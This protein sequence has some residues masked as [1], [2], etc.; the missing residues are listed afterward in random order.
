MSEPTLKPETIK[1]Q[2]LVDSYRSGQ[3]VIPEF[4]REYVWKKNRAPLLID[5]LYRGFPVSSLLVWQSEEL[6]R[7]RRTEPRVS[8]SRKVDWLI[9]GQQRVITLSRAF[10]GDENIDV[11]FNPDSIEFQ[12]ANAATEKDR[13]WFHVSEL[14]DDSQYRQ[15]RKTLPDG[16]QSERREAAFEK[17][18]NILS[19]EIPLLRMINHRFEDAV[20]AFKRINRMGV[21]LKREDLESAEV[22]AKHSGF[23]ADEVAPYLKTLRDK[24]FSRLTV[25]HLFRACEYVAKS[26][27]RVRTPLH[28][29]SKNEVLYAWKIAKDSTNKALGLLKSELGLSNMNVFWSGA[30][31]VP[32]IALCASRAPRDL[33]AKAV[34][35]WAALAALH[36]R[37][38][39]ST[40]SN[41]DQDL[42]ACR[43][44][45]PIGA[46]LKNLRR[47]GSKLAAKPGDF[48]G[49][50]NDKSALLAAYVACRHRGIRDFFTDQNILLQDN[51]DR[52]HI[53][54]RAQFAELLRPTA[55]VI[56]NI[57][58]VAGD[59][60]RSI[61][62]SGPEVYLKKI[63]PK[64]LESQC[65]PQDP[66]LWSIENADEFWRHRRRL[67]AEAF[68]DYLRMALPGRKYVIG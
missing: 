44:D 47:P 26:D 28:E 43:A 12:L 32:M 19:Y 36:H 46:L 59:V 22:A 6:I 18:R 53:L 15:I 25:M 50:L 9:D 42:R 38:S 40:E 48:A 10:Y 23:I 52:H 30:M 41:L 58:F 65:V 1:V 20:E 3:I 5:S 16:K 24:G 45:D 21:R 55:D 66:T 31:F 64:T 8:S 62:A 27:G 4:Q 54:P 57:A 2:F 29:L 14:L 63:H 37:Y 56:A 51:I 67:L 13:N 33:D 39:K 11:V 60:N 35:A 7:P 49:R 61:S 68:N 17:L 34:V